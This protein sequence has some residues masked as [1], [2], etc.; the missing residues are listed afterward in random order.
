MNNSL[1]TID[2]KEKI[3]DSLTSETFDIIH[4]VIKY[5]VQDSNLNKHQR[6][7]AH[8]KFNTLK[9]IRDQLQWKWWL[10]HD[11]NTILGEVLGKNQDFDSRRDFI[12]DYPKLKEVFKAN[13]P[14]TI[15]TIEVIDSDNH[16]WRL[17]PHLQI[18]D[19]EFVHSLNTKHLDTTIHNQQ[20]E[21]FLLGIAYNLYK[22]ASRFN[23]KNEDITVSISNR[24]DIITVSS[25]N[26]SNEQFN[27]Q[28]QEKIMSRT[29]VIESEHWNNNEK[30]QWIYLLDL[31]KQLKL[32]GWSIK[33]DSTPSKLW[34]YH[35]DITVTLPK[36]Q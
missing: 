23:Q 25:H 21:V 3:N 10:S 17:L 20:W 27:Q 2:T 31:S 5:L 22:N 32:M 15:K 16:I 19:T 14:S 29:W 7:M 28:S 34:W 11:I 24:W 6:Y 8:E 33:I 13:I 35:T 1:N 12:Q 9:N 30:W 26:L 36:Q 18:L 4:D